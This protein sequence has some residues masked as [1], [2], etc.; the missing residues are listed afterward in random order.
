[1]RC[2]RLCAVAS[3][4]VTF[5]LLSFRSWFDLPHVIATRA[6]RRLAGRMADIR[7][8]RTP[9]NDRGDRSH[10]AKARGFHGQACGGRVV[11][12]AG[13]R[14]PSVAIP[15]RTRLAARVEAVDYVLRFVRRA[16]KTLGR[17]LP[18]RII[19]SCV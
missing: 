17:G 8:R 5:S 11:R 6:R 10:I 12:R 16:L 1:M 14:F 3:S 13:L 9:S 15:E 7:R 2:V 4:Q 18:Q 19:G